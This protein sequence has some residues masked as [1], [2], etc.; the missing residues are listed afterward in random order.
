MPPSSPPPPLPHGWPHVLFLL[1]V[2]KVKRAKVEAKIE[3]QIQK[4]TMKKWRASMKEQEKERR[5]SVQMYV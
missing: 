1:F 4:E 3:K 2:L 5:A